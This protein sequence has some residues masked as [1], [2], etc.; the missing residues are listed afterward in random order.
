MVN[1]EMQ[2]R[3][4]DI[5]KVNDD[6][7]NIIVLSEI[8]IVFVDKEIWVKWFMLNVMVIFNL[9][10]MDLG[11]LLFYI[12]YVLWY[13]MLVDD[14][15]QLFQLLWLI[16]CEIESEVGW[17]YLMWLLFYCMVDDY[18]DGVV[19]MLIDIIDWYYVEEVVCV[20]E[21]CLCLVVQLIKDYVII[22][23]DGNGVIVSW[24]VGVECIF[25]YMEEEMIGQDVE[26]IYEFND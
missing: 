15:W 16:E 25:G 2:V 7:Y 20:G 14:V 9:I 13:L 17:W 1:V 6:F 12:I 23:Q 11:W 19:I 24:N 3:I 4:E 10:D 22:I 18:I 5:V 8:V 26:L 21:Q